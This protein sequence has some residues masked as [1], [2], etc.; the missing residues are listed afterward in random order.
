MVGGQMSRLGAV[1]AGRLPGGIPSVLRI[2][3]ISTLECRSESVQGLGS[4]AVRMMSLSGLMLWLRPLGVV[5]RVPVWVRVMVCPGW[6]RKRWWCSQ[7]A[8]RLP[9]CDGPPFAHSLLAVVDLAGGGAAAA[10]GGAAAAIAGSDEGVFGGVGSAA[11]V[12]VVQQFA[13]IVGDGP[14][15]GRVGVLVVGDLAG[16]VGDDG[17]E[18][19]DEGGVVVQFGEG[20]QFDLDVDDAAAELG[21]DPAAGTPVARRRRRRDRDS[22][23]QTGIRTGRPPPRRAACSRSQTGIR[24]GRPPPPP[25]CSRRSR[26]QTGNRGL[27]GRRRRTWP[28]RSAP[29]RRARSESRFRTGKPARPGRGRVGPGTRRRPV[30]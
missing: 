24:T 25:R 11:G 27:A 14:F 12:A 22:R 9:R 13:V 28:P 8:S 7:R 20:A 29:P 4:S 16:D 5:H 1:D 15:P 23:S 30:G 18:A 2:S 19:G 6:P 21:L 26:F 17:S 10:A 3:A